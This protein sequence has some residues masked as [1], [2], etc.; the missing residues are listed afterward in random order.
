MV[1]VFSSSFVLTHAPIIMF[2]FVHIIIFVCGIMSTQL[3][4]NSAR[5]KLSLL[6]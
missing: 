4:S 3:S 2:V 1:Y 6:A 5:R